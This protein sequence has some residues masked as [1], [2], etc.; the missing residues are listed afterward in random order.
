MQVDISEKTDSYA[1]KSTKRNTLAI[2]LRHSA[3]LQINLDPLLY[4]GPLMATSIIAR[5]S[6]QT[7]KTRRE[8]KSRTYVHMIL[9]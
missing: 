3:T 9:S 5:G 6:N 2:L 8:I 7:N 4:H 1:T